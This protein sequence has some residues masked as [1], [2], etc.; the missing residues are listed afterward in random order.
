[1]KVFK[2]CFCFFFLGNAILAQEFPYRISIG[3][4]TIPELGGIQSFAYGQS[5]G[6]WVI[7]GG[8]LDGLHRREPWTS[9]DSLG[10][11]RE[12]ILIDPIQQK[13][14]KTNLLTLPI[15]LRNQ[16]SSTNMEFRQEGDY[17]ILIGGY[18]IKEETGEHV[19]H[20]FLTIVNVPKLVR[21]IELN[22]S[23]EPFFYQIQNEQFAVC[24]G[25]LI[26]Q[27]GTFYLVG[28]HRFDGRYNP[29]DGPSFTQAYT[30]AIRRFQLVGDGLRK[31]VVFLSEW[32]NEKL[33][34]RRDL[35]VLTQQAGDGKPYQIAF[36]GVFQPE[37]DQPYLTS[38]VFN[39][40][41]AWIQPQFAQYFN[42][43]H[44]ASVVLFDSKN[45]IN[46]NLFFGG[47]S[48]Y[49]D[50]LGYLVQDNDIPFVRSISRVAR[51]SDGRMQE[52]LLPVEMPALLGAA[53]EFIVNEQNVAIA[54]QG[55]HLD[56]LK[57]DTTLLGYIYGGI[58]SSAPNIFWVN[59]G[60]QS[61]ASSAIFPVYLVKDAGA[62]SLVNEFSKN[63]IQL[64]VYPNPV[65]DEFFYSFTTS[66]SSNVQLEFKNLMGETVCSK[67]WKK[68]PAGTHTD[69]L[70][71]RKLDRGSVYY[72]HLSI[73]G[74]LFTQKVLVN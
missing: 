62:E 36:S 20:P 43:Y 60:T 65:E 21:A 41:S 58:Q 54:G 13:K 27:E 3:E 47:I 73:N 7:F 11:N 57:G 50:S 6:K 22:E 5:Q 2:W 52:F 19:T 32:K 53:S 12:L 45:G 37:L 35:N 42:H 48:Q 4:L 30:D 23:I 33:F 26:H 59:E 61:K 66:N 15:E 28:G 71:Y 55:I 49:Y 56:E 44:C 25:K 34:H 40:D 16:L 64:Q 38:V 69:V 51:Y 29:F 63:S 14:W 74:Q 17:L 10:H 46:H 31:E 68:L 39:S 18:G 8:R 70:K 72:L 67:T 24:G 9:F 1:M